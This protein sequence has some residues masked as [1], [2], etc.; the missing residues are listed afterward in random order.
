MHRKVQP[1]IRTAIRWWPSLK[2]NSSA[3]RNCVFCLLSVHDPS[4]HSRDSWMRYRDVLNWHSTSADSWNSIIRVGGKLNTVLSTII[5]HEPGI[6]RRWMSHWLYVSTQWLLYQQHQHIFYWQPFYLD[7]TL[8]NFY[9]PLYCHLAP[10]RTFFPLRMLI[11]Y[12]HTVCLSHNV[13]TNI[14]ICILIFNM[15]FKPRFMFKI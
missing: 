2:R 5:A 6:V 12:I 1:Q 4:L 15:Y 14:F 8:H 7:I 10:T 13:I 9:L 3:C 11:D